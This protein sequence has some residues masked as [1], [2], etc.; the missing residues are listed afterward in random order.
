MDATLPETIGSFRIVAKLGQGGMGAVYHAIHGTLERP[1]ALKILPAEFSNNPEYVTRFLREARTVAALS[2][3]NVVKVYDA[4]EQNGQYFIA[5]ELVDG[6]NLQKFV[7][8]KPKISEEEGL[9]LLLMAAKGLAAAHNKGLV[10]RDIKPENM[11]L[12]KDSVLRLVD[13]G[14]VMESTSTT[15]LTAT[16]ACLGTPMYMSPEQA[17]GEQ[18][19]VR[20]DLYS[21]GVTFYRVFTG[22]PPFSSPT[23]MNLLFKHKF[24]APP[25][26]KTVRPELSNNVRNLLLHLMAKRREDRPQ[27]AQGVVDMIEG[28]KK[29]KPVPPPPVFVPP[30]SGATQVTLMQT[31]AV[32][33]PGPTNKVA[34][35]AAAAVVAVVAIGG[36]V[37]V[38]AGK[39]NNDLAAA[40]APIIETVNYKARGD[41][42]YNNGNFKDALDSYQKALAEKP[43]PELEAKINQTKKALDFESIMESAGA[44]EQKGELDAAASKYTEAMAIDSGSKAKESLE[45]VKSALA[46]NK[47]LNN[48]E[49]NAERD[50][51]SKKA[52]DAEKAGK[53]DLAA[54]QYSRAA[55]LSDTQLRVVFADKASECRRQDYLAK[56]VAAEELKN[57]LEAEVWYKKALDMKPNDALVSQQLDALQKKLKPAAAPAVDVDSAFDTAMREGQRALDAADYA[58][59]RAQFGAALAL[60]PANAQATEKS[61][62]TDGR[63]LLVRGD[64]FRAAGNIKS[65]E[66]SYTEAIQKSPALAAEAAARIKA[67]GAA[68]PPPLA[69]VAPSIAKI[70]G[71]VRAQRD[72][73]AMSELVAAL[74]AN[75]GSRDLKDAKAALEGLQACSAIYTELDKIGD[76]AVNRTRDYRDIDDDDRGRDLKDTFEKLNTRNDERAKKVRP[77]FLDHNY[78]A[79][80]SALVNARKDALELGDE[81]SNASDLCDRKADK[82]GEKSTGAKAFGISFGV[83]GDKKKAQKYRDVG[84]SF[85][86]LADQAKAQGK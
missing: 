63:E 7:D 27:N 26:P 70:D 71:L 66:T 12:G 50:A 68:N 32:P 16:G 42:A 86:K 1:V 5:M 81:L 60:K 79:V 40:N 69:A 37:Y 43:G 78:Q 55:A 36:A 84:E 17:D 31:A 24:E 62:E 15:Q 2:H 67:L 76:S 34:M 77:L 58:H 28:I 20:T 29:G 73:E 6:V 65:A 47:N 82:A 21:L 18:A 25:D 83:G 44:L 35:I 11:L 38:L 22:Q 3:D 14:L 8:E 52:G 4:G 9:S 61:R 19:D 56:A 13:F 51:L 53:Y 49:K 30:V 72:A 45:R 64:A 59:A 48:K 46:Q 74:R 57:L 39:K 80:Q 75:P 33:S 10:H 85:K 41:D 54:E 23:V